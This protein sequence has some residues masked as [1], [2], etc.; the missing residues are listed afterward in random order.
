MVISVGVYSGAESELL[1]P[2]E[3]CFLS[4]W[5]DRHSDSSFSFWFLDFSS[6]FFIR[7]RCLGK[8]QKS[9]YYIYLIMRKRISGTGR[10]KSTR[11]SCAMIDDIFFFQGET[12]EVDPC[13]K[14]AMRESQNCPLGGTG[15]EWIQSSQPIP[16]NRNWGLSELT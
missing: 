7:S 2:T 6:C 15:W 5:S 1:L 11:L 10:K 4:A 13:E 8:E 12:I 16:R 3:F 9:K 14:D